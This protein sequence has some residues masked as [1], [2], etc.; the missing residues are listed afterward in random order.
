MVVGYR[1]LIFACA[2]SLHILHHVYYTA[3]SH[4]AYSMHASASR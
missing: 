3:S 4:T 1:P 2:L